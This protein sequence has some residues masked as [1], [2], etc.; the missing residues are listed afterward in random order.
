MSDF[1]LRELDLQLRDHVL[2]CI[3][4]RLGDPAFADWVRGQL[5]PGL[6]AL[7]FDPG[8]GV[9]ERE[10]FLAGRDGR[11]D[12]EALETMLEGPPELDRRW[13]PDGSL[14]R[15][16]VLTAAA[17]ARALGPTEARDWAE[18]CAGF[19][20][21]LRGRWRE[22][23]PML[24]EGT[25]VVAEWCGEI[26]RLREAMG[27]ADA[28]PGAGRGGRGGRGGAA[29]RSAA[30]GTDAAGRPG[31]PTAGRSPGDPLPA[32]AKPPSGSTEDELLTVAEAAKLVRLSDDAVYQLCRPRDPKLP[33]FRIGGSIKIK[34]ADLF[35]WLESCRREGRSASAG[36]LAA[37]RVSRSARTPAAS[38]LPSSTSPGPAQPPP[39]PPTPPTPPKPPKLSGEGL[40]PRRLGLP[41]GAGAP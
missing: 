11:R 36:A 2:V 31:K 22:H 10:A 19:S 24:R 3:R 41:P 23:P 35:A 38:F 30:A 7:L 37:R 34:R 20:A 13:T 9:G 29:A 32:P 14:Y 28:P 8:A 25:A 6:E 4:A 26:R 5:E 12:L 17:V 40:R 18:A 27:D 33:H 21:R 15:R 16:A 1:D 39:R